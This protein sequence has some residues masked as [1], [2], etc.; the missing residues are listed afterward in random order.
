[1]R[2]TVLPSLLLASAAIASA[3]RLECFR[4]RSRELASA[5]SCGDAG[6]LS[7]CFSNLPLSTPPEALVQELERC[8]V[9][10]GCTSAESKIE[11][12]WVMRRC[13]AGSP[14]LRRARHQPDSDDP[15]L[16]A[17]KDPQLGPRDALPAMTAMVLPR[18]TTAGAATATGSNTLTSPSPCFTDSTTSTTTCPVQTTGP[19]AGKRLAC[20]TI[21]ITSAVCREG[22]I[23]KSDSEGNPSC[24]YKQSALGVDGIII[25]VVFAGAL[26]VGL[27]SVC[28]LCCRERAEHQRLE[29]AAEAARIAKEAKAQAT[30]AAKRP[31][32]SV[33]GPVSSPAVEGQPLMY[34][35]GGDAPSS[36]SAQQMSFAQQPYQLQSQQGYGA[37]NP[38][39]DGAHD[40]HA[41]R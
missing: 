12:A 20:S 21:V 17:A 41:L 25:A 34:Q 9:S 4:T 32:L 30:A 15:L 14:D 6:S 40:D 13:D 11:G 22:L 2:G 37:P 31:G 33:T 24:M 5:A 1:M 23:C 7:D 10:A 26:F 3:G 19:D 8:F 28:I 18:Q 36:P 39:A 29:R 16:V 38:F 27:L 35:G